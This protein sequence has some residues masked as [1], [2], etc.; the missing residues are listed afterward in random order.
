M[1]KILITGA[2][3]LIGRSIRPLMRHYCDFRATDIQPVADET[4][5]VV[6][7][8]TRLEQV[9]PLMDGVDGVMHL[10]IA[11]ARDFADRPDGFAEAQ[12]DVNAKGTYNVLEAA[13]RAGVPRVVCA[14]SVMVNWGYPSERYISLRDPA[15]PGVLYAATKYFGEVL[16]RMYARE[17]GLPVICWRI[18]QPVDHGRTDAKARAGARDQGVMVSF[19][20]IAQGFVRAMENE[21][22]P[23]G[24]YHLVSDNP[25]G[26]CETD[27]ARHDLGYEPCHRFTLAG[28]ET[29]RS[30]PGAG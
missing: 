25:D 26:Y 28:V 30:W 6:A 9:L 8:I 16:S 10:A 5:S 17:H 23:F 21:T 13:R 27:A 3:G 4:D 19:V 7:D 29:L 20:D 2:G 22:I 14:S 12:L 11:S 24:V 18:G 15:R 1:K